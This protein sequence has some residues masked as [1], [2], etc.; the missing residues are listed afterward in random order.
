M[1]RKVSGFLIGMTMAIGA[2][3]AGEGQNEKAELAWAKGVA[4]HFFE[5]L[6]EGNDDPAG[7]LT[8]EFARA[9]EHRS[10][11]YVGL[12]K[13]YTSAAIESEEMAPGGAEAVFKG[14]LKGEK[15]EAAFV[16]RLVKGPSGVWCVRFLRIRLPSTGTSTPD[17]APGSAHIDQ[18]GTRMQI[19]RDLSGRFD[20]GR[21]A[22]AQ[23]LLPYAG[24][25]G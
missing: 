5:A 25:Y 18:H 2:A 15:E 3:R 10:D 4:T 19:E 24:M 1:M 22:F 9:F 11:Y 21:A 7:L 20:P 13:Q 17:S 6:L 14:T 8:P 23:H 12:R 16:A